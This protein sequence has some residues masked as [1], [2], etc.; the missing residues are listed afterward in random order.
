ML[1]LAFRLS[2]SHDDWSH[3]SAKT[4][5]EAWQFVR[6]L[7]GDNVGRVLVPCQEHEV[8]VTSWTIRSLCNAAKNPRCDQIELRLG[9]EYLRRLLSILDHIPY[10]AKQQDGPFRF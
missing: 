4:A 9:C 3:V 5:T 7:V 2:K 6:D 8:E 1:E 10:L